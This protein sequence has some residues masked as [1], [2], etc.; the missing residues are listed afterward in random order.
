MNRSEHAQEAGVSSGEGSGEHGMERSGEHGRERSVEHGAERE[1]SGTEYTL[2]QTYDNVRDGARLILS[3]DKQTNA[4]IGIVVNTT[5]QTLE[6]V[7]V[8]IHLSKGIELGPTTPVD[9]KPGE[10]REVK[11][12]VTSR[13]FKKW[14]AYVEVGG[15]ENDGDEAR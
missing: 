9:L 12:S 8:E 15:G 13:S 1:E 7:R 5:E 2:N 3:Y 6:R 11:L 10:K 4:F 14:S